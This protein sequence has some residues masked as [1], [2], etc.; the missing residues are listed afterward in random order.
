MKMRKTAILLLTAVLATAPAIQTV[1]AVQVN[2]QTLKTAKNGWRTVNGKKYYYKKGKKVT[3]IV[4]IG[5]KLYAFDNTGALMG[6]TAI[7]VYNNK[8]YNVDKK[9]VATRWSGVCHHAAKVMTLKCPGDNN[10][11][12]LQKAFEWVRDLPYAVVAAPTNTTSYEEEVVYY[13][14]FGLIYRTGDCATQAATFYW[15]A[16]VLGYKVK[17]INGLVYNPNNT[18]TPY[19][20]HSWVELYR[21]GKT[22]ICDPNFSKEYG[23]KVASARPGLPLG[24][25]VRYGTPNTLR[26]CRADKTEIPK[27]GKA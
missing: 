18:Q 26:Y 24:Y 16:S 12:R 19:K 3:G 20:A 8:Y 5:T 15:L 13:G 11:A 23:S 17:V 6:K 9:G 21:N 22:Y 1:S 25:R 2:A 7:F 4:K 27:Y 10:T 14:K